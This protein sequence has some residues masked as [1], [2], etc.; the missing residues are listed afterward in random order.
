MGSPALFSGILFEIQEVANVNMPRL[1]IN[2]DG[3]LSCPQLI[4]GDRDIICDL[5]ERD[6]TAGS[7]SV[8]IDK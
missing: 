6:D 7:M 4:Y 8:P 1:D 2:S 3:T 5:E